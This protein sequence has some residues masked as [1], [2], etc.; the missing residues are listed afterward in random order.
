V[1]LQDAALSDQYFISRKLYPN[2]EF[3]SGLVYRALGFL[4][5]YFTVL[6]AIPRIVGYCAHWREMQVRSGGP[7]GRWA[8][9]VLWQ[10]LGAPALGWCAW[11]RACCACSPLPARVWALA[12]GPCQTASALAKPPPPP[13]PLLQNDP[14]LKI[15]RPQQDYRGVWLRH[16]ESP[17]ARSGGQHA[18]GLA[19]LPPSNAYQRRV[20]GENWQ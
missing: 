12:L 5:Q 4:P 7:A 2:V 16:Y 10:L 9:L 18:D 19:K 15:V 17:K 20:A 8:L 14:D 1:A 6:F 11:W 3:Y 13:P